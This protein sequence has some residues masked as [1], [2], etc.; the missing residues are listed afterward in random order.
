MT[1]AEDKSAFHR[2]YWNDLVEKTQ[3]NVAEMSRLSGCSRQSVYENIQKAGIS[4]DIKDRKNK[5]NRGNWALF[6]L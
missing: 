6:G 5:H 3:G 2:I 1:W 4:L